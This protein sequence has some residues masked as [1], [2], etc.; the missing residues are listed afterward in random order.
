MDTKFDVLK[1]EIIFETER[2]ITRLETLNSAFK[3]AQI[4][5]QV[6]KSPIV[7]LVNLNF[8]TL[9]QFHQHFT[10]KFFV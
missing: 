2:K 10:Y 6:K 1:F 5:L 7:I 8:E 3:K 9:S 4:F